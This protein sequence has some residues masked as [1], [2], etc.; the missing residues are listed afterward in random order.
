MTPTIITRLPEREQEELDRRVQ[1]PIPAPDPDQEVERDQADL[2]EEVEQHQIEREE[3]AEHAR[4]HDEQPDEELLHPSVDVPN[5]RR[6]NDRHQH[7]GQRDHQNQNP[8]HTKIK[9]HPD[10]IIVQNR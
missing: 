3:H 7:R 8:I 5:H 10:Y 1:A 6:D 2:P 9:N 4:L